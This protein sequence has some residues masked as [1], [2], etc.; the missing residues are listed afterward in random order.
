MT[1][2][3]AEQIPESQ[4]TTKTPE[5]APA[6]FACAPTRSADN[7]SR[8]PWIDVAKGLCI[9]FIVICHSIRGLVAAGILAQGTAWQY[10]DHF[11]YILQVPVFFFASG[12]FAE[13]SYEKSGFGEFLRSKLVMLAYP[14]AIWQTLQILM[15]LAS[16]GATNRPVSAV[17]LLWL[18]LYP[19]MQFWFIYVLMLVIG[20]YAVFKW[21]R[22]SSF[23]ILAISVGMLFLPKSGWFPCDVMCRHMVYFSLALVLRE[24]MSKLRSA[25]LPWLLLGAL[26][27][28]VA[29]ASIVQDPED[30]SVPS[31]AAYAI[32]G[33]AGVVLLSLALER[34]WWCQPLCLLGQRSLEIFVAH[35][36]FAA[37]TRVLLL[38][39]LHVDNLAVHLALGIA[40]SI[41]G[42]LFLIKAERLPGGF[43]LPLFRIR[44]ESKRSQAAGTR[45]SAGVLEFLGAVQRPASEAR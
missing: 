37:G 8:E 23:A 3:L 35:T 14:Y 11:F 33:G 24:P 29:L 13:R 9:S 20:V 25:R 16:A 10:W 7:K 19:V 27:C 36:V 2:D 41:L 44:D 43:R 6:A 15:M 34:A 22:L 18:P 4:W 21:A 39:G 40:A 38:K 42:P 1:A 12:L 30:L 31:R 17:Q 32:L 5:L 45:Q 28:G 26:A